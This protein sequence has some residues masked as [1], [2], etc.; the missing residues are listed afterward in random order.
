MRE[1]GWLSDD[2]VILQK[3]MASQIP[4]PGD[5]VRFMLRD[6]EDPLIYERFHLDAEFGQ[7]FQGLL[8]EWAAGNGI[9]Q[10]LMLRY[11][12][13]HWQVP[14]FGQLTE[15]SWRLRPQKVGEQKD[16]LGF[17]LAVTE[18]DL[19]AG[20]NQNDV[21]P[22]WRAKLLAIARPNLRQVDARRGFVNNDFSELQL[23]SHYQDL[24]FA[25]DNL[26]T[27]VSVAKKTKRNALRA[28][29]AIK[30]YLR[31]AASDFI[32]QA[33]LLAEGYA[34]ADIQQAMQWA[35]LQALQASQQKC[36]AAIRRKYMLAAVPD[37]NLQRLLQAQSL[38]AQQI[39]RLATQWACERSAKLKELTAVQLCKLYALNLVSDVDMS[40]RLVRLGYAP[41]AVFG[42]MMLCK[43]KVAD[44]LAKKNKPP[45][46]ATA[47]RAA[48]AS[49]GA[50]NGKK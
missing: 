14:S 7:K 46:K 12:R 18:D 26:E 2:D 22:F 19:F 13:A 24:G 8:Q 3:R 38:S 45:K 39:Q 23:R 40:D 44:D 49:N 11:W 27:L 36:V 9:S 25:G 32:T 43:Q 42:I 10:E 29:P 28:H 15:M 47:A 50:K 37:M 6:V 16:K 41:E 20:L 30:A 33:S 4:G 35:D 31:Y 5:I 1:R 34:L 21:A 17:P 48:A